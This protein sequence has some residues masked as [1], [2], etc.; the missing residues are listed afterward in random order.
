MV[1]PM[2]T[3]N[4]PA[5]ELT[6]PASVNCIEKSK[7]ITMEGKLS[8]GLPNDVSVDLI[9]APSGATGLYDNPNGTPVKTTNGEYDTTDKKHLIA[10]NTT[11]YKKLFL[12][13]NG[14]T[15]LMMSVN[16]SNKQVLLKLDKSA[17]NNINGF[18]ALKIRYRV[19]QQSYRTATDSYTK[20]GYKPDEVSINIGLNMKGSVVKASEKYILK[21]GADKII[22]QNKDNVEAYKNEPIQE[23]IIPASAFY[24]T[25]VPNF[26]TG[27]QSNDKSYIVLVLTNPTGRYTYLF[28]DFEFIWYKPS[29]KIDSLSLSNDNTLTAGANTMTVNVSNPSDAAVDGA[30]LVLALYEKTSGMLVGADYTDAALG[31]S[32]TAERSLTVNI[33][34]IS[35]GDYEVRLYAVDDFENLS[36]LT[37]VYALDENGEIA[38]LR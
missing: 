9:T 12:D 7:K 11:G 28:D 20:S 35:S 14:N 8:S 38:Q 2:G 30:K 17:C 23:V 21:P 18:D 22:K 13:V 27:W 31:A 19:M 10:N 1:V 15:N 36:P 33:A 25:A 29:I 24:N 37:E 4:V 6:P 16:G 26:E 34:D 3:F 32:E 5:A